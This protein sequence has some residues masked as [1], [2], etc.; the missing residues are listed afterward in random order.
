[1]QFKVEV[2][3]PNHA[4]DVK[5]SK[6]R[7]K[8]DTLGFKGLHLNKQRNYLFFF[9]KLHFVSE[10]LKYV[11][12]TLVLTQARVINISK[13]RLTDWII[14]DLTGSLK[15]VSRFILMW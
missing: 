7:I 6:T 12:F 1:M 5:V 2:K 10:K 9:L 14:Y 4:D 8:Y 13:A 3:K 11:S 15:T